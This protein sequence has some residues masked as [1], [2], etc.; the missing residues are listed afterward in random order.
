MSHSG[1]ADR[2]TLV[3]ALQAER[4]AFREFCALLQTERACLLRADADAL[5]QVTQQKSERVDRLAELGAARSRHLQSL[6]LNPVPGARERWLGADVGAE[7]ATLSRLWE[8]LVASARKARDLNQANGALV[9]AR[10]THNQAA[11]SALHT[12]A[13]AQSLYGPD[14]QTNILSGQRELGQA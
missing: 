13:R 12:S 8:E 5:V 4:D 9:A 3:E 6:G 1:A 11:L 2:P 7:A 14:G 10:L